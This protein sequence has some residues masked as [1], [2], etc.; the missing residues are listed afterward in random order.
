MLW[1]KKLEGKDALKLVEAIIDLLKDYRLFLKTMTSD[2]GKEFEAHQLISD[3][4]EIDCYFV[5][6][7]ASWQKCL[8]LK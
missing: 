8:V 4:F 7:N 2:N 1:M 6:P 3:T 5:K